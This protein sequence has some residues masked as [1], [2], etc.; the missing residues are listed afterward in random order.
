MAKRPVFFFDIDNCVSGDIL[1]FLLHRNLFTDYEQLYPR[2]TK[3]LHLMS[4]LID[5]YFVTHLSLSEEDAAVLHQKYYKDYGLAIEGL[6]RHHTVDPLDFNAKVDDA[7]PLESILKPNNELQ[8]LLS[9]ID[10]SK[11]KLWLF[12]NAYVNHGKRVVRLLGIENY[13]EGLTY[14]DYSAPEGIIAK[15]N[16]EMFTKAMTQAGVSDTKDCYFVGECV[17]YTC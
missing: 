7:L 8:K 5:K 2:S 1:F 14:C 9:D 13:F 6:V 12:T 16:R 3:I 4:H 10:S 17:V 11:V 15:P